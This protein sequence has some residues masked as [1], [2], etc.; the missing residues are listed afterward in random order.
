MTLSGRVNFGFLFLSLSTLNILM[1][2]GESCLKFPYLCKKNGDRS[3]FIARPLI[4][5]TPNWTWNFSSKF[6]RTEIISF[7]FFEGL[8]FVYEELFTHLVCLRRKRKRCFDYRFKLIG[9]FFSFS[10]SIAVEW[11]EATSFYHLILRSWIWLSDRQVL[12]LWFRVKYACSASLFHTLCQSLIRNMFRVKKLSTAFRYFGPFFVGTR[13][14][15]DT[16]RPWIP[17]VSG[18]LNSLLGL[19]WP[20]STTFKGVMSMCMW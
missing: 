10:R 2:D 16:Y 17:S 11:K 7:Y 1:D 8:L 6:A 19:I 13:N 15:L 5:F 12:I 4:I 9:F 3:L 20:I 14:E 18:I